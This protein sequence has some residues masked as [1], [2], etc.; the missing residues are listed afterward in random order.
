[1]RKKR[2]TSK[3]HKNKEYSNTI[4]CFRYLVD[5]LGIVKISVYNDCSIERVSE[6]YSCSLN[7]KEKLDDLLTSPLYYVD[8][9][10]RLNKKRKK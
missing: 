10:N 1:M 5:K 2:E 4:G 8:I 6:I 3:K 9:N 7:N